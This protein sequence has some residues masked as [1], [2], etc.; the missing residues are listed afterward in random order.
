MNEMKPRQGIVSH[1]TSLDACL[2]EPVHLLAATAALG[3]QMI[4]KRT[5]QEFGLHI[6]AGHRIA[7]Q[8]AGASIDQLA[9]EI[10]STSAGFADEWLFA[11]PSGTPTSV[12]RWQRLNGGAV[13]FARR[14]DQS[15]S[16]SDVGLPRLALRTAMGSLPAATFLTNGPRDSQEYQS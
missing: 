14:L 16:H 3:L 7:T 6:V 8:V 9:M 15:Q 4:S 10:Y 11:E 5:R 2:S 13:D 12:Q 1:S